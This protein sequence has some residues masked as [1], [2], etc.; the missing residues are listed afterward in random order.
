MK[1]SAYLC[2][3][4]NSF[5]DLDCIHSSHSSRLIFPS[6]F[7]SPFDFNDEAIYANWWRGRPVC[8][9]NWKFIYTYNQT[10]LYTCIKFLIT[11]NLS[12][13]FSTFLD[14]YSLVCKKSTKRLMSISGVESATIGVVE[15]SVSTLGN[16]LELVLLKLKNIFRH[17]SFWRSTGSI[18]FVSCLDLKSFMLAWASGPPYWFK[19][20]V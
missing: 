18:A 16:L 15:S 20:S 4:K 2:L 9:S 17:I 11:L 14:E 5:P 6:W 8:S 13:G 19:Y 12:W 10:Y 3:A 1:P 7:L